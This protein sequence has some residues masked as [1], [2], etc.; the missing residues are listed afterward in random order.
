MA[1]HIFSVGDRVG[2]PAAMRAAEHGND[3]FTVTARMPHVGTR[4]QYRVKTE[5]EP[6][7]RVVTEEQMTRLADDAEPVSAS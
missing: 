7:E 4:L 6:Y 1:S 3:V 5:G 2:L